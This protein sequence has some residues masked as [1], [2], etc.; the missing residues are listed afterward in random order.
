MM[1]SIKLATFALALALLAAAPAHADFGFKDVQLAFEGPGGSPLTQAGAHPEA[2][3]V[4]LEFNRTNDPIRGEIPEQALRDLVAE[5]PPGL[6][7]DPRA[8]PSCPEFEFNITLLGGYSRCPDE[9]TIGS[10]DLVLAPGEVEHFPVFNLRPTVGSAAQ[11][12][13]LGLSVP[14]PLRA[15]LKEAP[16][17]NLI[18]TQ[19]SAPQLA[20]L[21]SAKLTLWG[22]PADP[23]HDPER[24]GCLDLG[25]GFPP[26]HE[27]CSVDLPERP[28]L[29]LPRSCTGP[30]TSLFSARS[31]EEPSRW[32]E[33]SAQTPGMQGCEALGLDAS[34]DSRPTSTQAAAN[35][36]LD[37]DLDVVDPGLTDP[38]KHAGSDIKAAQVTLPAGMEINPAQA[39]GL[40]VC[41]PAQFGQEK[42]SST[43]G[44]GCPVGSKIGSVEAE[45]PLLEGEVLR[46]SV[47]V[48]APHDNPFGSLLALYMTIKSRQ[49]GVNVG[50]AGKVEPIESGPEAGRIRT[51][52][53]NL[54]QLPVSHFRFHF[55]GGPRS[56]LSTPDRC[57][58]YTTE[59]VL[60]PWA[61]PDKPVTATSGF[62][63]TSGP[64][65]G[66]CPGSLLPFAPGFDG[67]TLDNHAGSYSPFVMR[68]SRG[69]GEAPITRLDAVLPQGVTGKLAGVAQCPDAALGAAAARSGRDEISAPSCPASSKIGSVLAGA[70]VGPELTYVPGTVYLAGPYRGAPLSIA[71]VT[72]AVAGPF[73]LGT[74][75]IREGLDLD[76]GTAEVRVSG[77]GGGIPR[78]LE[79]IPLQLRDLRVRIDRDRFTLNAT[80]CDRRTL[81]ATVFGAAPISLAAPYRASG[82]SALG[83]KPK[84]SLR[85]KGSTTRNGHP[86]L[87]SVLTPRPGDANIARA[88]VTLPRSQQIDNAH[89]NNPCTRV[90]FNADQCPPASVLGV[91]RAYTPLLDQP[92]EGPV[93]FRS[94]GGERELPDI[95]AQLKGQFEIVLVGFIDSK[96]SRLRTTFAQVPDAPVSKFELS[97]FGGKRGLLVNNRNLCEG[98]IR[99]KLALTGQNGLRHLTTP[100]LKA[101]CKGKG[102]GKRRG[103]GR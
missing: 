103:N 79:G 27:D 78:F 50:L 41:T 10:I 30:L 72:P 47:F 64:G 61:N 21:Y 22:H 48:A 16:P 25:F 65:G 18:S 45:T 58:T 73:D 95:V 33:R 32:V 5:L 81:A 37:F 9:S 15:G 74:V 68:I 14:V 1:R 90:Q 100:L 82:C 99:T 2:M 55:R 80:G 77:A 35:T 59:A 86:A 88:V 17:F 19:L 29:T 96:R 67:G 98:K 66:P 49:L 101:G 40:E 34:I 87:H 43:F 6:V 46:G 39:E 54:P 93:Y 83:F 57:G 94:N 89:I 97:L 70:G 53:E 8:V 12:G 31:W 85:L 91:A 44:A 24:G 3:T 56:P 26:P 60:T 38:A 76:P 7:G 51:S 28:F 62:E 71:V 102:A 63:V 69:D 92:L 36:G 23:A 52:F 42:S 4:S 84:L 75:V 20:P 11:I 13:F